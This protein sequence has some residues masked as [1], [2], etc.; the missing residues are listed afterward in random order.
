MGQ[1]DAD[2]DEDDDQVERDGNSTSAMK[3]LRAADRAK[4]KRIAELEEQLNGLSA[5]TRE[6]SVKDAL[7]SRGL[8]PKIAAFVPKDIEPTDEAVGKWL[9]EYGDVFGAAPTGGAVDAETQ[10]SL[11]DMD[12]TMQEASTPA[13]R[14]RIEQRIADAQTQEELMQVL[15]IPQ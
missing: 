14:E 5:S 10:Q 4:A 1:F 9:D 11:T 7:N 12:A 2:Y 8:N 13:G 6:R 3:Q 15:G